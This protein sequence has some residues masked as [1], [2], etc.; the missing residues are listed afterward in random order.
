ML[1]TLRRIV[2]MLTATA[3]LSPVAAFALERKIM[4]GSAVL[5]TGVEFQEWINCE[6]GQK[7]LSRR[8]T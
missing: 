7:A 3:P 6:E 5:T 4:L 1:L 8:M 2:G